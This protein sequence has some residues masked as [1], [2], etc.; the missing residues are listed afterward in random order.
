MV[1]A[2]AEFGI[3]E[4]MIKKITFVTDNGSNVVKALEGFK[5]LYCMCHALN[6]CLDT[7]L[8][9]KYH[10]LIIRCLRN[11]PRALQIVEACDDVVRYVK[12]LRRGAPRRLKDGLKNSNEHHSYSS[13]L[14]S[15]RIRLAEVRQLRPFF[16]GGGASF[17]VI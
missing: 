12:G 11:V 6:V 9:I 4:E 14:N 13:M 2:L 15:L 7:G 17:G 10:E 8:S 16:G 5:R 3:S 1:T